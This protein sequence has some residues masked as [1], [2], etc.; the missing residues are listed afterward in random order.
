MP[1]KEKIGFEDENSFQFNKDQN[2][3]QPFI[4]QEK[5]EAR[6]KIKT[7]FKHIKSDNLVKCPVD[8]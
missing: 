7:T 6:W 4:I 8:N 1:E 3:I 2:N 5:Q